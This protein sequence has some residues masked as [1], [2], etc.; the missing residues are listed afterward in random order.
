[1]T[2]PTVHARLD[3]LQASLAAPTPRP[4]KGQQ[5]ISVGTIGDHAYQGPGPCRDEFFGI[6]CGAHRDEHQLTDDDQP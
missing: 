6:P 5:S 1:M 4:L 3:A 2:D